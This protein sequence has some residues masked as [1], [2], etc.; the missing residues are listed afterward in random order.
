MDKH[1]DSLFFTQCLVD[2]LGVQVGAAEPH[3]ECSEESY[4]ISHAALDVM[5]VQ[6]GNP[7]IT[8]IWVQSG[9]KNTLLATLSEGLPQTHLDHAFESHEEV[10]FFTRGGGTI[11]LSGYYIPKETI[12]DD[13]LHD[14]VNE[15]L[16]DANL[17][18][19]ENSE[20]IAAVETQNI[21]VVMKRIKSGRGTTT[22]IGD[23][24]SIYYQ[25]QLEST[26]AIVGKV[27]AGD[28]YTFQL[29]SDSVIAAWNIGI[30]GMKQGEIRKLIC[31]PKV[32]YGATG[33]PGFIPE[34]ATIVSGISMINTR[35]GC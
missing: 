35:T 5:T 8:Q 3:K 33:I 31:E 29:G 12:I 13:M 21:G 34:N 6:E 27:Q 1:G 24:V 22:Q 19:K 30:V 26:G 18:E 9:D 17:V 7:A 15:S 25:N 4:H 20:D 28:G 23:T 14:N 2:F 10:V 11:H 16:D 32:A